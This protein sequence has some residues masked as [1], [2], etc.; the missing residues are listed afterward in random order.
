M[1]AGPVSSYHGAFQ[2]LGGLTIGWYWNRLDS[3]HIIWC[4]HRASLYDHPFSLLVW[5][6]SVEA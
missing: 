2:E 6:S 3:V 1:L 4:F 5:K